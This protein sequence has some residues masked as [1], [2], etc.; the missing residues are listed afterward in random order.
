MWCFVGKAEFSIKGVS[1]KNVKEQK[2]STITWGQGGWKKNT[3]INNVEANKVLAVLSTAVLQ[4]VLSLWLQSQGHFPKGRKA[5]YCTRWE[6]EHTGNM[7]WLVSAEGKKILKKSP[8]YNNSKQ[9]TNMMLPEDLHRDETWS[10]K[11]YKANIQ[12]TVLDTY[13]NTTNSAS[14]KLLC[15]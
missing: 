15:G 6:H 4:H 7:Q 3:W 13:L 8:V 9:T 1:R 12:P 5:L 14:L 11:S 2:E 10:Q